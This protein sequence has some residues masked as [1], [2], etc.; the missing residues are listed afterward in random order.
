MRGGAEGIFWFWFGVLLF[1]AMLGSFGMLVLRL[2]QAGASL[3]LLRTWCRVQAR[4]ERVEI[5]K[6][7]EAIHDWLRI[8]YEFNLDGPPAAPRICS[9]GRS[10]RAKHSS[11]Q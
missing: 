1:I 2:F 5:V 6:D 7:S 4:V 8:H 10:R 9:G 11:M 3:I